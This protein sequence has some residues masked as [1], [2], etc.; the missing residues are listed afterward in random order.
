MGLYVDLR[1]TAPLRGTKRLSFLEIVRDEHL[2]DP[3]N[4][5]GEE[6][7]YDVRVYDED[8]FVTARA[9]VRH[10]Y[11][12]GAWVLVARAMEAANLTHSLESEIV[13]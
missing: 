7:S 4:P 11:G 12:D 2:I 10:R 6:H 9:S 5:A 1:I 8:M 13:R 3:Q